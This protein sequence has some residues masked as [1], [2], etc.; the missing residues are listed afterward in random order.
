MLQIQPYKEKRKKKEKE[1]V[2]VRSGWALIQDDWCPYQKGR[3]GGRH[4]HIHT[5]THTHRMPCNE[6]RDQGEACVY[7]PGNPEDGQ[8]TPEAGRE[9]WIRAIF[10]ASERPTLLTP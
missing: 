8:Q 5:H 3:F 1:L 2:S 4:T 7:K 10:T 9:A 6:G